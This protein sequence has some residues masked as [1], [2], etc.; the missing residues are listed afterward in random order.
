MPRQKAGEILSEEKSTSAPAK[1]VGL[2]AIPE[3][4]KNLFGYGAVAYALGFLTV[5]LNTA[6][7]G[8]TVIEFT[9]A[10]NLWVGTP[11]TL[12]IV[13]ALVLWGR[14]KL[15]F[16]E[17]VL[18]L[19]VNFVL[20]TGGVIVFSLL[21]YGVG[22]LGY[23]HLRQ[24]KHLVASNPKNPGIIISYIAKLQWMMDHRFIVASTVAILV[25][26]WFVWRE[27]YDPRFRNDP[28][29]RPRRD[30]FFTCVIFALVSMYMLWIYPHLPQ[31]VWV[32]QTCVR[33]VN[34]QA[35]SRDR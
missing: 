11:P 10:L 29:A 20:F 18:H 34:P 35:R 23:F 12:A 24:M 13:G 7:Y 17:T 22:T 5:T 32:W 26:L 8:V 4:L 19:L 31:A 1:A 33:G 21:F 28:I 30:R 6:R 16:K 2:F 9:R 27:P 3:P 14:A 25:S 15:S